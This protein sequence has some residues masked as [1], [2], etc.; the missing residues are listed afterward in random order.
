[1]TDATVISGGPQTDPDGNPLTTTGPNGE[2]NMGGVSLLISTA[3]ST[4][5]AFGGKVAIKVFTTT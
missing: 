4:A 5:S 1:M 2:R 3:R